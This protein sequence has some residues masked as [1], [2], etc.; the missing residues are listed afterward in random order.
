MNILFRK[1]TIILLAPFIFVQCSSND[2]Y[3]PIQNLG[4]LPVIEYQTLHL[5]GEDENYIPGMLS[6]I[7]QLADGSWVVSDHGSTTIEH[8]T[9]DG[10][11]LSTVAIEGE[12]PGEVRP[13]FFFHQFSDSIVVA[14]QQMS[15]RLDFYKLNHQGELRPIRTKSM[16]QG[17]FVWSDLLPKPPDVLI[18]I[19]QKNWFADNL[20]YDADNEYYLA[21]VMTLDFN[22]KVIEDSVT[23][24]NLP[25]PRIFRSPQGGVS[26]F[27]VPFRSQDR[28]LPLNDGSYWLAR[29]LDQRFELFNQKHQLTKSFDL[30]IEPRP[31]DR[32]DK[33]FQL[34]RIQ[35]ERR[36]DI[37]SRIPS[38][39]PLFFN[40]WADID[41]ILLQTYES[42][43]GREYIL[44]ENS[45]NLLGRF[46]LPNSK[47]VQFIDSSNLVVLNSDP[48]KGHSIELITLNL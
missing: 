13:F 20:N 33:E 32:E 29:G 42:D 21:S 34:G 48:E 46:I 3:D 27:S 16:E 2:Q 37:E 19:E 39:K 24:L 35:G 12:G 9:A 38:T 26:V 5:I 8:F 6:R 40:A 43:D 28:I 14:R 1:Y 25:N 30:S 10:E 36:N 15:N 18:A 22:L 23:T 47:R 44:V 45:G 7:F 31:V 17:S 11:H 41:H 4:E